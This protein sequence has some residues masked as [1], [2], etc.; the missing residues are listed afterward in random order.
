MSLDN[1]PDL[2]WEFIKENKKVRKQENKISTKKAI[3]KT[4]TRPRKRPRK[5]EKTFFFFLITFLVEILFSCFL[6]FLC[7]FINSH[8]RQT[9]I[10]DWFERSVFKCELFR[11]VGFSPHSLLAT[12]SFRF[13]NNT[14]SLFPML[15]KHGKLFSET[16]ITRV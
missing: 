12:L 9:L 16:Q 11:L 7:S 10:Q 1:N 15:L 2:R 14:R 8:F 5:K 6:T 13:I 3:K 4:I